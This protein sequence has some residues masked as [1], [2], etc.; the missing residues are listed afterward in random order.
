MQTENTLVV[1]C[2]GLGGKGGWKVAA[3]GHKVYFEVMKCSEI[4]YGN[5]CTTL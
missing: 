4:R 2:Q 5:G 3:K 1:G